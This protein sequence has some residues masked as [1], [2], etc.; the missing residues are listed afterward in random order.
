MRGTQLRGQALQLVRRQLRERA[1]T[2][3]ERAEPAGVGEGL[4]RPREVRVIRR[5]YAQVGG[6]NAQGTDRLER[7]DVGRPRPAIEDSKLADDGWCG[8]RR[9]R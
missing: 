1:L 6:L 5:E 8:H 3:Q 7:Y 2:P 9:D 4:E